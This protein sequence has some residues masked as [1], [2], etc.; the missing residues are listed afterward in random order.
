[1]VW[2]EF[3]L[4]IKCIQYF[5]FIPVW[6]TSSGMGGIPPSNNT[7]ILLC[8]VSF[9]LNHDPDLS[10]FSLRT[11]GP[12]TAG[13]TAFVMTSTHYYTA[14][15]ERLEETGNEAFKL[16]VTCKAQGWFL[17]WGCPSTSDAAAS[18]AP[19]AAPGGAAA[20]TLARLPL[21]PP[22]PPPAALG[23]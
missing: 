21:P 2:G 16:Y 15:L 3:P 17:R 7:V 14:T 22:A 10:I 11:S 18:P 19:G 9:L 5:S 6:N 4:V 23:L 8:A 20:S 1:V 12:T 13:F